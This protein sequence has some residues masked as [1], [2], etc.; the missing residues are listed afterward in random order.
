MN[1]PLRFTGA[2]SL[3]LAALAAT[4]GASAAGRPAGLV[5][6]PAGARLARLDRW[7]PLH[8]STLARVEVG[9]A[10]I[11]RFVYVVGG[12]IEDSADPLVPMTSVLERY[13]IRRDRWRR[14]RPMPL[15]LDHATAVA[16]R[17]KLYVHGGYP[18]ITNTHTSAAL[19]RFNPRR[20]R[21][22]RLRPSPTPRAA[23]AA[24]VIGHRLYVA[25]GAND[26]GSLRSLEIYDFRR[27]R[28][29]PGPS[30]PG[31]ARNH[32]QGVA[33]GGFFYVLAGRSGGETLSERTL[34]PTVGRSYRA[35]DRYDPRRRRWQRMP[36]MRRARS[37]FGAVALRDGRI[38]VFGGEDW[39]N[40]VPGAEIIGR[41]ESFNPNTRRWDRLPRMRTPRHAPGGAALG[42]RVYALEG[43]TRPRALGL[44]RVLEALDVRRR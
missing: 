40:R 10:R 13:D 15:A 37:G 42:N 1:R 9:A 34:N 43:S 17:G 28:W 3:L 38:V 26:S 19:F 6:D 2:L 29:L 25:G 36:P 12:R 44:S 41:V 8:R 39:P 16:Y 33:S 27:N 30:F 14:L 18:D 21:W 4:A 23:E 24:A 22:K 7:M 5:A 20:N 11:G 35:V 31:P 32:T